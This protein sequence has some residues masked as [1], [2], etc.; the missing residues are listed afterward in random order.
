[1]GIGH[2]D[3]GSDYLTYKV[4][5]TCAACRG[6]TRAG[7]RDSHNLFIILLGLARR[8]FVL[9]ASPHKYIVGV[10]ERKIV[11]KSH[12]SKRSPYKTRR[13]CPFYTCD[14]NAS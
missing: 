12:G 8:T 2:G 13:K 14:D 7:A 6:Q 11:P 4:F 9:L 10:I 1:M 3:F 5:L